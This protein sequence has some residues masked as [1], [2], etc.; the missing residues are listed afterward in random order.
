[1]TRH[2]ETM[3]LLIALLFAA[4]LP[5]QTYTVSSEEIPPPPPAV[6]RTAGQIRVWCEAPSDGKTRLLS[7]PVEN[8]DSEPVTFGK[9]PMLCIADQPGAIPRIDCS[10]DAGVKCLPEGKRHLCSADGETCTPE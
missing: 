10:V 9:G 4:T 8:L 7:I 6:E 5:A 1:M 3:K 2:K